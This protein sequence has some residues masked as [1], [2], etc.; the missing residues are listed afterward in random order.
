M[1]GYSVQFTVID[2]AT[3]QIDQINRRIA[4]MRAPFERM[5]RQVQKFIDVSGLKKVADGFNWIARAAGTVLRSLTAIVPVLGTI[6]GAATITGMVKLVSSFAAWGNQL[7]TNAD[8]IGITTQELQK[9]QDATTRAGGSAADMAETLKNLHQISADAFTGMNAEAAAYF[10]RFG[11]ALTDAN[12]KLRSATELLPEV[13][14]ALDSLADP[15]DR[16]KVAAA[17]LSDAQMKVYQ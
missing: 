10:R 13:F 7:K 12:G 8:Q 17:L 16:A 6:T 14:K 15:A 11:I 3:K 5:S 9:W 1:P 2:N 4:A